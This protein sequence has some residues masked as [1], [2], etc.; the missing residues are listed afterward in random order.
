M[1]L[2]QY[3][4]HTLLKPEANEEQILQICQEAL[5]HHFYSVC[6]NSMYVPLC[7]KALHNSSVKVCAVVGF[8]LGAMAT[9]AKA[10]ETSWAVEHGADEID[11]V[12]AVG[13]LK[14]GNKQAVQSDI[15]AVVTAAKG[16]VVKVI[17]ETNLL[18]EAE[19]VAAC[20]LAMAAKAHFVKTSTGFSG[21]G[22]TVEDVKLMKSIVGSHLKVKASGG[23]KNVQQAQ[24]MIHAGAERLGTS[25]GIQILNGKEV[26]GGY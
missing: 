24:D 21:G 15:E 6:V 2:S 11:M 1:T 20:E 25:S 16:K 3:I 22:A 4:D 12:L 13:A 9:A 18:T 26:T 5:T 8:P 14:S 7:K 10:F 17:I 23:I 19:K